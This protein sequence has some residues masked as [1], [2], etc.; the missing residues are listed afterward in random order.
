MNRRAFITLLGGAAAW[1]L[2]ARAQQPG[3][4]VIGFLS[5]ETSGVY[6]PMAAAFREGLTESGYVEGRNVMIEHRWA[7]GH[8]DRLPVL[9]ADLV[10]RQVAV[11]IAAGTA[12]TIAA[13]AATTTIP[14]V[15]SIA[16]DPVA[17]GF[18]A[19][20]NRPGGNATG[21]TYLGTE[22][23]QKQVE[24]LREMVPTARIMAVLVNP[25]NPV[26]AEPATKDA[27][28]AARALGLQI[29][30][31]HA[32]TE[33]DVDSAFASLVQLRAG[34]LVVSPDPFFISR[35]DQIA[36]LAIRHAIP[37][38]FLFRGLAASGLLMSYGPSITEGYR[39]VGIYA[40]RILKGE[41]PSELPVQQS[42][43]F[44]LVINLTTAKVLGL[45]VP[46]H[47]QQLADE[48]IE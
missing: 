26:I 45:D 19:S 20:L 25:S 3:M 46:L 23:V 8:N 29:H 41:R 22:L 15:F 7:Q 13:K 14:I 38:I 37:A 48:V 47:L 18:V 40:A 9:A 36:A 16:T 30:V 42:T 43:K 17:E 2:A 4:R 1:P 10:R 12:A 34:A 39:R 5:S 44:D 31:I 35:G 32:S 21:V 24:K 11:I 28:A 33:R 27:H 6:A